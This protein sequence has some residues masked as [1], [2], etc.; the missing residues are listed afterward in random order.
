M[1]SWVIATAGAGGPLAPARRHAAATYRNRAARRAEALQGLLPS[2]L[3]C[4]VGAVAGL[5]YVTAV[6]T[7]VVALWRELALPGSD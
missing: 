4:L 3:V 7:P 1:L 6:F 2:V 5:I